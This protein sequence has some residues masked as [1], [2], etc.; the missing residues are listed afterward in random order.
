M[1]AGTRF[2]YLHVPKTGG[3]SF[4]RVLEDSFRANETLHVV[5]TEEFAEEYSPADLARY[6]FIH[7]HFT[8]D[9]I[10]HVEGFVR[11]ITLRDPLQRCLS[12]YDFWRG[13]DPTSP[14]WSAVSRKQITAANT[15]SLADLCAHPDPEI[16]GSFNDHQ[17]RMLS[18]EPSHAVPMTPEHLERAVR[19]LAEIDFIALA[20]QLDR[21]ALL[22]CL[23][24]G[25]FCPSQ[26]ARL[27][28]SQRRTPMSPELHAVLAAHNAIDLQLLRHLEAESPLRLSRIDGSASV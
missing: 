3:V 21:A 19:S 13:Q 27:N 11:I 9:Q 18:G 4:R 8:F 12:T 2:I 7:G 24:F 22:L 26:P 16:A 14:Q 25:L 5:R 28:V 10:A 20:E 1:D 17:T 6:R 15:L 23:R